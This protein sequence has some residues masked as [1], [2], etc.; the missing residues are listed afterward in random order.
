MK[1]LKKVERVRNSSVERLTWFDDWDSSETTCVRRNLCP[2]LITC[3]AI[4]SDLNCVY[5]NTRTRECMYR[6][7]QN[8]YAFVP[9]ELVRALRKMRK[10]GF[11]D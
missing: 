5:K 9:I 11:E 8:E 4:Q 3:E 6:M 1:Q 7:G 2:I 10:G